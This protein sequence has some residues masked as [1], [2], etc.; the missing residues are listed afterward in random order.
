MAILSTIA[1]PPLLL[2][3]LLDVHNEMAISECAQRVDNN[4]SK[5]KMKY[6]YTEQGTKNG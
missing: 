2:L 4:S 6:L 5:V 3:L 1:L